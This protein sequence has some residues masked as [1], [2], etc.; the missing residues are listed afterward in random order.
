[1]NAIGLACSV[2]DVSDPAFAVANGQPI[3][4]S[5]IMFDLEDQGG[6]NIDSENSV[7]DNNSTAQIQFMEVGWE[8]DDYPDIVDTK[9]SNGNMFEMPSLFCA[10]EFFI[11]ENAWPESS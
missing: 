2:P 3:G 9:Q 7:I 11:K 4:E 8:L 6:I 10:E 5:H 1:M